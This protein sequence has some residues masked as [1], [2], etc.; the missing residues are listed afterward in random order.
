[1]ADDPWSAPA[2]N[3]GQATKVHAGTYAFVI[4]QSGDLLLSLTAN[5]RGVGPAGAHRSLAAGLPVRFAGELTVTDGRISR[6][7]PS[8]GNYLTPPELLGQA[9]AHP[10]L[11]AVPLHLPEALGAAA[12][13]FAAADGALARRKV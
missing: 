10:L 8:S 1:M 11:A 5:I 6:F 2:R 3:R 9:R 13:E 4:D 7:T 12:K